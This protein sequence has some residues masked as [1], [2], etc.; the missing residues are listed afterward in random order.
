MANQGGNILLVCDVIVVLQ[1][2]KCKVVVTNKQYK[3][4]SAVVSRF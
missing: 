4:Y 1:T 2:L 3:L